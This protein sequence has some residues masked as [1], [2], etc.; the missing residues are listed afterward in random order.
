MR[1]NEPTCTFEDCEAIAESPKAILVKFPGGDG[2]EGEHWVPKSQ[3]HDDSEVYEASGAGTL[4]VSE[5]LAKQ[6]GW[7]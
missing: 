7:A 2:P 4:V 3:I 1:E 6:K 5:W